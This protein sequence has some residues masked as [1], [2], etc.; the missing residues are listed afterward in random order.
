MCSIL[1][2]NPKNWGESG[3]MNLS[4]AIAEMTILTASR[5][6]SHGTC[7]AVEQ[8]YPISTASLGASMD[9]KSARTCL[10]M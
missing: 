3:E 8:V 10:P 9:L 6:A 1:L 2:Y 4:E 7:A 5:Y